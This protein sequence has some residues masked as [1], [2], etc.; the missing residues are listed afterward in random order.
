MVYTENPLKDLKHRQYCFNPFSANPTKWSNTL[1]K[2][3]VNTSCL[4]VSAHF[5]W[6]AVKGLR[7]SL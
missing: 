1:K 7:S 5:V 6:L 4:S 3:V 2:F